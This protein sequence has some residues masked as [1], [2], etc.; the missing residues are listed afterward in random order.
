MLLCHSGGDKESW[1]IHIELA[2]IGPE[3]PG[4]TS[5]VCNGRHDKAPVWIGKTSSRAGMQHVRVAGAS[6]MKFIS[7]R[8]MLLGLP[9]FY[10]CILEPCIH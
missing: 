3:T 9:F 10:S 4:T 1:V 8:A 5:Q 7:G 6:E 2:P